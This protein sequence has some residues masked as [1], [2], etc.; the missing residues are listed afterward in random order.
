MSWI[1]GAS[2]VI[3]LVLATGPFSYPYAFVNS[4]IILAPIILL[5]V[6]FAAFV[7]AQFII[8]SISVSCAKQYNGRSESIYAPLNSSN[9]E[10]E[11]ADQDRKESPFFI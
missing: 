8:E 7:S 10:R 4:G 9:P 2:T 6:L 3:N 5:L 1:A 11:D